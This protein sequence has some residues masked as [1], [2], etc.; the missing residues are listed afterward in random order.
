MGRIKTALTKRIAL[1][2]VREYR[3]QMKDNFEDN[4]KVVDELVDMPSHK[5]RNIVAGYVT[6]IIKNKQEF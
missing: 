3:S 1:K 6:R 5:I 4:K 2:L